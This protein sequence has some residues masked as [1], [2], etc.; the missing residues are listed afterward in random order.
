L[1]RLVDL[2]LPKHQEG[3]DGERQDGDDDDLH[4]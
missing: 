1:W 3:D 2:A 4:V